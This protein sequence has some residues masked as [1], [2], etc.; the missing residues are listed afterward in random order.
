MEMRPDPNSTSDAAG[1]GK[2]H[3]PWRLNYHLEIRHDGEQEGSVEAP[4]A[5]E[6]MPANLLGKAPIQATAGISE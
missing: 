4:R 3:A 2:R 5:W 1:P 6:P